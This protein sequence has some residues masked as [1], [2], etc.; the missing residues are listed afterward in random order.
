MH[1]FKVAFHDFQ[2][3]SIFLALLL[4]EIGQGLFFISRKWQ[5]AF[6]TFEK[7]AGLS[8]IQKTKNMNIRVNDL[9]LHFYTVRKICETYEGSPGVQ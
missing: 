3:E 6:W 4:V 7:R 8:T 1:I 9:V 2:Q 5:G